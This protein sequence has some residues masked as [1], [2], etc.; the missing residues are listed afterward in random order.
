MQ[1]D[2]FCKVID[3]HGDLGVCWRLASQLAALGERVRLW[4]DDATALHWMAPAGLRR[5][6]RDR[7]ARPRRQ[8]RQAAAAPPPDV[9]IEA[10]GCDPAPELI[11]RFAEPPTAGAPGPGLDQ[12]RIPVGG[13]LCRA[14]ARPAFAGVQGTGR[15]ADEALFLSRLHA[16]P[17]EG[18]CGSPACWSGGRISTAGNGWRRRRSPGAK[19]SGS[20][21]SSATNLP[22]LATNCSSSWRLASA[23]DAAPGDFRPRGACGQ[24]VF[25]QPGNRP[26]HGL[27]RLGSAIDFIPALPDAAGFRPSSVG[28]RPELRARRRFA[29]A[30]PLGRRPAGV[31]N[32]PAGR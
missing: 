9:L 30:R 19:A 20:C 4:I 28:L 27:S 25:L 2:I 1:W 17:P 21:R 8:S 32:L 13:T 3:N 5:R 22:A 15:G 11:A 7:L 29:G 6:E 12:S 16:R 26:D 18:C 14:A 24:G 23:A 31:A 10:F